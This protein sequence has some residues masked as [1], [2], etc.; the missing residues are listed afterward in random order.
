MALGTLI[1]N[2]KSKFNYVVFG[3][4][5]LLAKNLL[6]EDGIW[7]KTDAFTQ[8]NLTCYQVWICRPKDSILHQGD[9]VTS[10]PESI[11]GMCSAAGGP[12]DSCNTCLTNP[13]AKKCSW[14][15]R[16]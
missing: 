11:R 8:V 3:A 12:I 10:K 15:I 6:A 2:N 14:S 1:M 16:H 13:P 9:L 7:V 5:M 4:L